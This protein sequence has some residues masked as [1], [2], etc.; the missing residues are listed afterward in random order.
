MWIWLG[1]SCDMAQLPTL[2]GFLGMWD[3]LLVV[4]KVIG[5]LVCDVNIGSKF[6]SNA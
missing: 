1:C 4:G 5:G 2:V 6:L 3:L